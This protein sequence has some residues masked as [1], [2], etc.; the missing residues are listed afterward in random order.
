MGKNKKKPAQTQNFP[1]NPASLRLKE[2]LPFFIFCIFA[3]FLLFSNTFRNDFAMDDVPTIKDNAV[4]RDIGNIPAIFSDYYRNS[5]AGLYRPATIS[6][7]AVTYFIFGASPWGF[8]FCNILL[9]ALNCWLFFVL[10]LS[11]TKRKLLAGGA[12]FL[13]LLMPVHTEAVTG[14]V[15]RAELLSFSF[16]LLAVISFLSGISGVLKTALSCLLFLCGLL[17]KET[18]AAVLPICFFLLPLRYPELSLTAVYKKYQS[19]LTALGAIFVFYIFLR[20]SMLGDYC[21][22]NNATIV[23]NPLK[24]LPVY[25]RVLTAFKVLA[26]YAYKTVLPFNLSSDYSYNQ[27]PAVGTLSDFGAV[28]GILIFLSFTAGLTLWKAPLVM[29]GGDKAGS[30]QSQGFAY[31]LAKPA[32]RSFYIAS[33][34]FIWPFLPVSNLVVVIGTIMGERL[35]YFPSAGICLIM[36]ESLLLVYERDKIKPSIETSSPD[37][38]EGGVGGIWTFYARIKL[39]LL[40]YAALLVFIAVSCFYAARTWMRNYDWL[41]QKTLFFSAAKT[42][43]ESVLSRANAAAMYLLENNFENAEK[44]LDAANKIYPYYPHAVNNLGIIYLR[45]GLFD[46]AERQFLKTLEVSPGYPGAYENLALVYLNTGN[47][48][49]AWEYM[50]PYAGYNKIAVRK[51]FE[52]FFNERIR[53]AL[54]KNDRVSADRLEAEKNRALNQQ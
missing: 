35:M 8:H 44:E 32:M 18:S 16:S 53:A 19:V 27:I 43:P 46:K 7:Y 45:R 37:A 25:Q 6:S 11:L 42:C 1:D 51:Y 33:V 29:G 47:Y 20:I 34:L 14:L 4:I 22:A 54:S 10:I 41:D 28:S 9:H 48:K 38:G 17:A 36:A 21:F 13:F 3:S 30:E 15:G 26:L 12:A 5:P 2:S 50:L 40:K 23:E 52:S 49:K 31:F 39:K 24:F